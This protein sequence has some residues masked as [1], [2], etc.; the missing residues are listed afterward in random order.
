MAQDES[1]YKRKRR[2]QMKA[3]FK[4][5]DEK[6]EAIGFTKEEDNEYCVRYIRHNAV[7]DYVQ[8]LDI[9]HKSSGQHIVQSYDLELVDDKRIGNT[10]VGLTYYEM[11]LVLAKMRQKKRKSTPVRPKKGENK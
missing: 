6:F 3:L 10:C 11:K 8:R 9:L 7:Y 4:S 2:E 1:L 5:I